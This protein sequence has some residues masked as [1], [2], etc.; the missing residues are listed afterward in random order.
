MNKQEFLKELRKGLSG[1]PQ[2]DIE[3]RLSFYG[4]MIEDQIEEGL[5]EEEAVSKI[6]SIE[7]IVK[8][9]IAET[10]F[11]KIAKERIKPN[12]KLGAWEIVLLVLG[13]PIWIS[14]G[15]AAVAVVFSLYVALWAVIISFWA[16]FAALVGCS[17]GGIISGI[18]F[19]LGG[20]L[21]AGI[22]MIGS[23]IVCL[24][25]SVFAF[26]GCKALSKGILNLTKKATVRIKS[27]FIKK[28]GAK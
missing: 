22:A 19:A 2:N 1:L 21:F 18:I 14:L 3:D 11:V 20:N 15:V 7:E 4:E 16:V 6:G 9:V 17:F 24:G 13:S 12:R 28:E 5:R 26:I 23:G 25:L 10:P 8:A 27:R